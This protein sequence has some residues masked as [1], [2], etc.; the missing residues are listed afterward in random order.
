MQ[1]LL[2]PDR[3]SRTLL[4]LIKPILLKFIIEITYLKISG[5]YFK[6]L[7]IGQGFTGNRRDSI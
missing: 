3:I 4:S 2:E 1:A 6:V 5:K 7:M